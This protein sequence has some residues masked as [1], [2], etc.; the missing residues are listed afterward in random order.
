MEDMD[1]CC[2]QQR[3]QETMW[4]AAPPLYST[5]LQHVVLHFSN[6]RRNKT[7]CFTRIFVG[8]YF[9]PHSTQTRS[10]ATGIALIL[11][12]NNRALH[13]DFHIFHF[14][15]RRSPTGGRRSFRFVR[16]LDSPH[17][18]RI[19]IPSSGGQELPSQRRRGDGDKVS[20]CIFDYSVVS[21]KPCGKYP[22]VFRSL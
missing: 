22:G 17:F 21:P 14:D 1:C 3:G 5:V 10:S 12:N 7:Y 20:Y 6:S 19:T 18:Q 2:Y 16:S 13:T 9:I 8:I 11:A 4:R 15:G